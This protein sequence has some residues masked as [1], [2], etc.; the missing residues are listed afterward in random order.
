MQGRKGRPVLDDAKRTTVGVRITEDEK[1]L[2]NKYCHR[3]GIGLSDILRRSIG[4][5][6]EDER[7]FES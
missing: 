6:I 1:N 7:D 2:L 4:E 3:T 5:A